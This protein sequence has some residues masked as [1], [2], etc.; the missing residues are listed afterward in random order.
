MPGMS[1]YSPP[2]K[3]LN[4]EIPS[5]RCRAGSAG[6]VN[7]PVVSW[8]PTMGSRSS[9]KSMKFPRFTHSTGRLELRLVFSVLI[10]IAPG[11]LFLS[12]GNALDVVRKL[13][14]AQGGILLAPSSGARPIIA[15]RA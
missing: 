4:V 7:C 2:F 15:K 11:P 3:W 12:V 9:L 8:S 5:I 6:M 14:E 13:G 1:M 10:C